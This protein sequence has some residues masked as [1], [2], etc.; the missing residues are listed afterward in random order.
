MRTVTSGSYGDLWACFH[1][2][3]D[4]DDKRWHH[5][6][7]DK[8]W[9]TL[10]RGGARMALRDDPCQRRGSVHLLALLCVGGRGLLVEGTVGYVPV[11]RTRNRLRPADATRSAARLP[12][13]IFG[14]TPV[15]FDAALAVLVLCCCCCVTTLSTGEGVCNSARCRPYQS[16]GW[17]Y[18][19][20]RPYQSSV[21][22]S[23]LISKSQVLG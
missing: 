12:G 1:R 16:S 10:E 8:W 23:L 19:M 7:D 11:V 20:C 5:E 14:Q 13:C 15:P 6:R 17:R 9:P 21:V 22:R 2:E 18:G 3:R 4:D